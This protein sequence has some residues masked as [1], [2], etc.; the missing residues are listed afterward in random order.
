M[1]SLSPSLISNPLLGLMLTLHEL[2]HID[3]KGLLIAKEL[4]SLMH[5]EQKN[6]SQIHLHKS[7]AKSDLV[8][9]FFLSRL[10]FWERAA[11]QIKIVYNFPKAIILKWAHP[12]L[13]FLLFKHT[14]YNKKTV[15]FS[16]IQTLTVGKEGK[17]ADHLTTTRPDE[18]TTILRPSV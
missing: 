8:Y 1:H 18:P 15:S 17:H 3:S 4:R 6:D 11:P 13:F 10:A 16:G 9:L 14:F 7:I 5:S 2:H 12:S